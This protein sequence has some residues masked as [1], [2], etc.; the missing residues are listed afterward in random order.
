MIGAEFGS[1][2]NSGS[3]FMDVEN[4]TKNF[5][6][7]NDSIKALFLTQNIY[8]IGGE[9]KLTNSVALRAGYAYSTPSA[10]NRIGKEFNPNTVRTD[11][12][13]FVQ[14]GGTQY[15]SAGIGYRENNWYI[16][17]AFL[18]KIYNTK[19]YPYNYN[20]LNSNR[21]TEAGRISVS[22]INLIA[23]LGFRF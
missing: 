21:A 15:F 19:F 16:D 9:Y 14:N 12:E 20:K 6:Y 17:F 7:E 10:L 5:T 13:Y 22:N 4:D 2:I 1:S 8:K 3:Q 18:N 11:S 23:T